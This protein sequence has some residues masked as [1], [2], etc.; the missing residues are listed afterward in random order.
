M[1]LCF[2][3]NNAFWLLGF[4]GNAFGYGARNGGR[5]Q[6]SHTMFVL[7]DVDSGEVKGVVAERNLGFGRD[8]RCK[9]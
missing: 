2:L 5:C 3:G 4:I 9:I 1:V 8:F 7:E 6:G